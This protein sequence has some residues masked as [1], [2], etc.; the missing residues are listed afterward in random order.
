MINKN[1]SRRTYREV[2]GLL[3]AGGQAK[4]IAPLPFSKELYPIGF[5]RL[6]EDDNLRTKVVSHYLLEKMRLAE[7][8]LMSILYY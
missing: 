1:Q 4:R 6:D 2:I 8:Q 3:P 5:R 7:I